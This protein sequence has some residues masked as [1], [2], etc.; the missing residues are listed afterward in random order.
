M[1]TCDACELVVGQ[2]EGSHGRQACHP[3]G[4]LQLVAPQI[5][6]LDRAFMTMVILLRM[7]ASCMGQGIA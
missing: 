6:H 7:S 1:L 2:D 5:E 4:A 3:N